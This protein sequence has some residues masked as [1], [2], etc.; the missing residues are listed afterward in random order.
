VFV[1]VV[2]RLGFVAPIGVNVAEGEGDILR[3][4]LIA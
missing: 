2:E 1:L 3:D 4:R